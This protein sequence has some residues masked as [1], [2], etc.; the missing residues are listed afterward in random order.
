[1]IANISPSSMSY[2]D[3]SN[4]LKYANRAKNI[5]TNVQENVVNVNYHITKYTQIIADLRAEVEELKG[6]LQ[7]VTFLLLHGSDREKRDNS[8]VEVIIQS[9]LSAELVIQKN[10]TTKL[11]SDMAFMRKLVR[12]QYCLLAGTYKYLSRTDISQIMDL[13][14]TRFELHTRQ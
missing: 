3:T 2:E 5:K 14:L 8:A 12:D 7:K 6:K 11:E 13:T 10:H 9:R 1:M 4:T